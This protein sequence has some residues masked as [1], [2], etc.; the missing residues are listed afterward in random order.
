MIN[1]ALLTSFA[2]CCMLLGGS[3]LVLF[4]VEFFLGKKSR[5]IRSSGYMIVVS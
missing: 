5:S 2:L 3:P 1:F 4:E